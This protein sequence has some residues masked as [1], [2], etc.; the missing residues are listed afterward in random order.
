MAL[1][2]QL[3]V[4]KFG[5]KF[6]KL[7]TRFAETEKI[8]RNIHWTSS[9]IE[10]IWWEMYAHERC[11][12]NPF[13]QTCARIPTEK[14]IWSNNKFNLWFAIEKKRN[15]Q[16]NFQESTFKFDWRNLRKLC[17]PDLDGNEIRLAVVQ[18]IW[19]EISKSND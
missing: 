13:M 3:K 8:S 9:F 16:S 14:F 18:F 12:E 15:L 4:Y 2:F 19:M 17:L 7:S 10:T 11:S 5:W 1:I 6:L